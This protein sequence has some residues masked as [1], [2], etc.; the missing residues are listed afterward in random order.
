[1]ALTLM[2]LAE[3]LRERSK[4]LVDM[5]QSCVMFYNDFTDFESGQASKVFN[6]EFKVNS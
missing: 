2:R 3:F 1:M 5:A 4:S 6:L